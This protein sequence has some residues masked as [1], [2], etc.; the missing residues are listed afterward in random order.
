MTSQ[1]T[2]AAR[3]AAAAPAPGPAQPGAGSRGTSGTFIEK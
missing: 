3:A 1:S 2:V